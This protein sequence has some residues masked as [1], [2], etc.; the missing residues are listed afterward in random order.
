VSGYNSGVVVLSDSDFGDVDV[1]R[2]IVEGAGLRLQPRACRSE[3]DLIEALADA[4]A[5]LVQY[6]PVTAAVLAA[7]PRLRAIVRFGTGLDNIDLAAAAAAGVSVQGVDGYCVEEV[8]E[9]AIALLL[10]LTRGVRAA[11]A[12]VDAGSW[13]T[14][15]LLDGIRT[16]AGTELGLVGFGRIG[17]AV[18]GLARGLGMRVG[19]HDPAVAAER[20]AAAGVESLTLED[21]FRR[22]VVSLHLPLDP[23]SR[24]FVNDR[25]LA[26]M[27]PESILLNVSR[28]G[29]VDEAALLRALEQ[30]RP[31]YAGLDVLATEPAPR[32]HPLVSHPRVVVTPHIAFYSPE[33]LLQLRRLAATAVV[34]ALRR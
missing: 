33:S 13:R 8:A 24:G 18:A 12:A 30:R 34:E 25:L 21:A 2:E 11:G 32:E 4:D 22:P 28:G 17:Q 20:M 26:L 27:P 1:E 31:A 14:D 23:S 9:H 5:L 3:A 19:A 7:A 29:L 10:A 6:A 15:G 16:V